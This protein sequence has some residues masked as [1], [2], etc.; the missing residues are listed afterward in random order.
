M[1]NSF[2]ICIGVEKF[3]DRSISK[4]EYSKADCYRIQRACN[5]FNIAQKSSILLN[6]EVTKLNI[7]SLL[8]QVNTDIDNLYLYISSHGEQINNLAYVYSY[9]TKLKD[10]VNTAI[11]IDE[12]IKILT[13]LPARK[14][15]I[16]IDAC[17]IKLARKINQ[18]ITLYC[19]GKEFTFEDTF[20]QQSLFTKAIIKYISRYS[21]NVFNPNKPLRYQKIRQSLFVLLQRQNAIYIYGDSGLGKSYILKQI[22]RD[23]AHTFYISI[24][25]IE[26]ISYNIALTLLSEQLSISHESKFYNS[27][28]ADPERHIR[29][30]ANIRPYSLLIIDHFDHLDQ[31]D[32]YKLSE[33]LNDIPARKLIASRSFCIDIKKEQQYFFPKLTK[34]DIEEFISG[35]LLSTDYNH[36]S[37][38]LYSCNNYIDLLNHIYSH[39]QINSSNEITINLFEIKKVYKAIA[40]SG[41]FINR[42]LF[43]EIFS[44]NKEI[45]FLLIAKGLIIEHESFFYPHDTIYNPEMTEDDCSYLKDRA[46]YYWKKEILSNHYSSG[47]AIKSYILLLKAFNYNLDNNDT[48][49]YMNLISSLK[50]RQNTYYLLILYDYFLKT[51]PELSLLVFMCESLIEIGKFHEASKLIALTQKQNV[52][53]S[54]L[55]IELLWWKGLFQKCIDASDL[56]LSEHTQSSVLCSRG[57]ACFFLGLWDKSSLDLTQVIETAPASALKQRYLSY[58]VLATTQGIRGTDFFSCVENFMA[59]IKIAKKIGKLSWIALI[60]GNIGEILWKANLLEESLDILVTAKHLAYLTGNDALLLEISRNL[61]HAHY[62]NKRNCSYPYAAARQMGMREFFSQTY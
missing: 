33:F 7:L 24:P 56:L 48:D 40:I 42:E 15:V 59:A 62:K 54:A 57:I 23:E 17:K 2:L 49:F 28:D 29:F 30:Y 4:L 47:K 34:E 1:A 27:L 39:N 11:P 8:K 19:P 43:A 32:A 20:Y 44:L 38:N 52:E 60:Y 6:E 25:K 46:R 16:V 31:E 50:G 21:T 51:K 45:I 10:I 13:H 61:L 18:K 55:S 5:V 3:L 12:L 22:E 35:L 37:N 41:G 14:I 58:C 53:L 9:E 36:N 26:G